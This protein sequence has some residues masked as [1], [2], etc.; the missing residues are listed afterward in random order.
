LAA[1]TAAQPGVPEGAIVL[2]LRGDSLLARGDRDG[3]RAAYEQATSLTNGLPAADM[4]LALMYEADGDRQAAMQR[5]RRVIAAE[6]KHAMALNNLA[7]RLATDGKSPKEALPFAQRAVAAAPQSPTI[8]DTLAW[9]QYLLGDVSEAVSTMAAAL[10]GDPRNAE[11]RLHA[12]VIYAANGARAVARDQLAAA[13]KL[14]P[15]LQ[16]SPEV[17]ALQEKL[18]V[19]PAN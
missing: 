18:R 14:D 6:P 8:L 10:K 4:Q 3:A 19:S 1:V 7:Y 11:I 12:A 13:L 16:D 17:R 5:Y 2:T 9:V 15:A